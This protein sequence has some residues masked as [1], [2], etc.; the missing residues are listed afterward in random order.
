MQNDDHTIRAYDKIITD[1]K[2]LQ[3]KSIPTTW[4]EIDEL[5]L[6]ARLKEANNHSWTL[7][8]GLAAVQIG[9]FLQVAWYTDLD[10]EYTLVNPKIISGAT[11]IINPKEGCLSIP[12][13]WLATRR[14][15]E[16]EIE[17]LGREK[18]EKR[19]VVGFE[20]IIVQHEVDHMHGIVNTQRRYTPKKVAGRNDPCPCG[21]G[22]KYKKC[23]IDKI[24]QPTSLE[25]PK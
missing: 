15:H 23:C 20:A 8:C 13:H 17:T 11:P 9:I 24:Q 4:K 5:N 19:T 18:Y 22:K 1:P 14:Y 12:G 2:I 21:S 6:I 7:G 10:K 25:E 16:L 3:K